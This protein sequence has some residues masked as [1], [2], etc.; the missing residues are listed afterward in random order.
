MSLPPEKLW[1]LFLVICGEAFSTFHL[2]WTHPDYTSAYLALKCAYTWVHLNF[3][4]TQK[5]PRGNK[6]NSGE[7]KKGVHRRDEF[8]QNV[9]TVHCKCRTHQ[10]S[11]PSMCP[12]GLLG[13]L[14]FIF[15]VVH[16]GSDHSSCMLIPSVNTVFIPSH[17]FLFLKL[18]KVSKLV[19][20][21]RNLLCDSSGSV[22]TQTYRNNTRKTFP[23]VLLLH[24]VKRN[25]K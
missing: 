1:W 6:C 15:K 16:F 3:I 20:F 5:T 2:V 19:R 9:N 24:S 4:S 17:F 13:I 12:R 18:K 11:D 8:G 22:N 7:K 25:L 10:G 23:E 14:A 21:S